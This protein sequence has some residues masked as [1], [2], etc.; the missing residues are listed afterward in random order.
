MWLCIGAGLAK[1]RQRCTY[2]RLP[3]PNP[4]NQFFHLVSGKMWCCKFDFIEQNW[5]KQNFAMMITCQLAPQYAYRFI[6]DS[7]H[8]DTAW[9]RSLAGKMLTKAQQA[10][11]K[12]NRINCL[13]ILVHSGFQ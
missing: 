3:L 12:C 8:A 13:Y 9:Q 4:D 11:A 5:K 7:L 6:S 1:Y 2:L 10:K